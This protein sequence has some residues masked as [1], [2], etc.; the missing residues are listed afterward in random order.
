MNR[1]ISRD[2]EWAE[3]HIKRLE[4]IILLKELDW[5]LGEAQTTVFC[6]ASLKG[7]GFWIEGLNEGFYAQVPKQIPDSMNFFREA[8]SVTSALN[9]IVPHIHGQRLVIYTDNQN[10]ADI[11]SSL[12]CRPDYNI[13]LKFSVDLFITYN[14][15]FKVIHIPGELNEIADAL[16]RNQLGVAQQLSPGIILKSFIP[17]QIALGEFMK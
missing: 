1:I 12:G 10:T 5:T 3:A 14:V 15:Q 6:D 11:F 13:L 4:G 9:E 2:L 17:P 7:L 16:S 8:L